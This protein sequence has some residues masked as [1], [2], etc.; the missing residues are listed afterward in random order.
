MVFWPVTREVIRG[1][2]DMVA[3]NSGRPNG[4]SIDVLEVYGAGEVVISEVQVP[5]ED[6]GIFR[7]VSIWTVSDGVITSG[8][9]Y[10]TLYGGEE[11][12][13]WRRKY[14]SIGDLPS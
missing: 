2:D 10:W 9:E 5:Q 12:A 3:V 8:R 13:G 7:V 6:V 4:W 14:T 11:A 1:R